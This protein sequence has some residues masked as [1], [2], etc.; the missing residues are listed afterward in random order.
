M[1]ANTQG[2]LFWKRENKQDSWKLI[3][4]TAGARKAAVSK[5]AMYFTWNV[6]D[7]PYTNGNGCSSGAEPN[8]RGDL[9]L[10]FDDASSPENALKD[11]KDLCLGHLRS[12]C[13]D[14][15]PGMIQYFASGGKGFHAIIPATLLGAQEGSPNLPFIYK[16]IVSEWKDRFNLPTL[17]LSLYCMGKGKMVRIENVKRENGHYKVP[18]SPFEVGLR[19]YRYLEDLTTSPRSVDLSEYE[20]VEIPELAQL[21]W[22]IGA[23]IHKEIEERPEVTPL[24]DEERARLAESL[25]PCIAHILTDKPQTEKTTFNKLVLQLIAYFQAAKWSKKAVWE[26]VKDFVIC[27]PY[28]G[29]YPTPEQRVAH[30]R[31]Q[32]AYLASKPDYGFGCQFLLGLGFSGKGFSCDDCPAGRRGGAI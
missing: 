24:S 29:S 22:D 32:W 5:G 18:L 8:R 21:Y 27:Y 7:E 13:P 19:P 6:F 30:W 11:M 2:Y 3:D 23:R 4:D 20:L 12:M 16:R 31:S 17:D 26:A 14:L 25:P 28:S 15:D 9:V 1:L 10:D